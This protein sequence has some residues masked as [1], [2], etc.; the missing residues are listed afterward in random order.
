MTTGFGDAHVIGHLD[1]KSTGGVVGRIVGLNMEEELEAE[2]IQLLKRFAVREIK[3]AGPGR[4][5]RIKI[6]I[7]II[8]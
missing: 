6:Y 2:Y 5:S 1:K 8:T 4:E 7:Y 3:M